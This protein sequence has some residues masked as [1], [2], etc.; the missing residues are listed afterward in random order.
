MR[1]D[2]DTSPASWGGPVRNRRAFLQSAAVIPSILA[3]R[4]A[5][6]DV[7]GVSDTDFWNQPRW[8]WL[9]RIDD[10]G[11]TLEES[12]EVYWADGQL[13]P[14]AYHR[15]SWA[16]RDLHMEDRL[17]KLQSRRAAAE[18]VVIPSSYYTAV[19]MSPVLL[20]TLYAFCGW[21]KC[22]GVNEP[23]R[24]TKGG[25]F[26][27]P[28]TNAETEGAAKDSKHQVGGA[29]DPHIAGV[30]AEASSRFALWLRAGGVGVYPAKHF[31]H[32]DDGRIRF[33]HG[34]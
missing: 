13:V 17:A 3:G 2:V 26:R 25:L 4:A 32:V 9:R 7:P 15:L 10:H 20:D 16:M 23:L 27:H 22:F 14:D 8:V 24:F 33:W 6:A 12:R 31:T 34:A 11:R 30:T 28:V 5:H 1:E 19:A 18:S 21:L 29:G